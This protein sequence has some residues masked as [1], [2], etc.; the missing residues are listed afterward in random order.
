MQYN[1][2]EFSI[3]DELYNLRKELEDLVMPDYYSDFF[4]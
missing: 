2:L 3:D 1:D 4:K